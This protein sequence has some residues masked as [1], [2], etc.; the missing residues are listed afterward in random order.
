M[1][2]NNTHLINKFSILID[3]IILLVKSYDD[4]TSKISTLTSSRVNILDINQYQDKD[5]IN[6]YISI[7]E[8]TVYFL[9]K[10]LSVRKKKLKRDIIKNIK[11]LNQNISYQLNIDNIDKQSCIDHFI[12]YVNQKNKN[13]YRWEKNDKCKELRDWL[14]NFNDI[15]NYHEYIYEYLFNMIT[16]N[17]EFFTNQNNETDKQLKINKINFKD[18]NMQTESEDIHSEDK[19]MQ[20]ESENK[21]SE[22]KNMQTE[23]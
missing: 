6:F 7:F 20:T 8:D 12:T 5:D 3:K 17:L 22:D 4:L 9:R 1:D 15:I 10:S 16:I 13:N 23:D 21:H 18:K 2:S 11:Y 14:K 19:N